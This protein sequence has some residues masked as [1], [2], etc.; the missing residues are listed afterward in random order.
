MVSMVSRIWLYCRRKKRGSE[1][2]PFAACA[3]QHHHS[4]CVWGGSNGPGGHLVPKM[5]SSQLL[6]RHTDKADGTA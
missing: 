6:C 2:H 4:V 1:L 5:L 3:A